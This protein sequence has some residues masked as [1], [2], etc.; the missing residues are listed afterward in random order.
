M[1]IADL[2]RQEILDL[3]QKTTLYEWTAQSVMKPM[4]VDHAKGIYFWDIDGKRYMDFNSQLMCVCALE[5]V[6][7]QPTA[8]HQR[9]ATR[10]SDHRPR[11]GDCGCGNSMM[12]Y[13]FAN[14]GVSE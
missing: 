12:R 13:W 2:S 10:A 8:D 14:K 11:I 5:H 7:H 9:G 3:S 1:T 6:L 4:V